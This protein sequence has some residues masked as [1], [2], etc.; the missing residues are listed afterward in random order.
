M[1][2]YYGDLALLGNIR[3]DQSILQARLQFFDKND[4]AEAEEIPCFLELV[5]RTGK[6]SR[7]Y[8]IKLERR[9]KPN[10]RQYVPALKKELISRKA[11]R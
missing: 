1:E 5:F 11:L 4:G 9:W 2:Q 8:V 10:L 6:N 3:G 7:E